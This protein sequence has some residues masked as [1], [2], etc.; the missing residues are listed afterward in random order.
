MLQIPN[1]FLIAEFY[2]TECKTRP[3]PVSESF[4][5]EQAASPELEI[6]R[7]ELLPEQQPTGSGVSEEQLTMELSGPV[8]VL[9]P[10]LPGLVC[11]PG[12]EFL[13]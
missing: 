4:E 9:D 8:T 7:C 1:L 13:E 11:R 5:V 2:V 6:E 10:E 12:E 3:G